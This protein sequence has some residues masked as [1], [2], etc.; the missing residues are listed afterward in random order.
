VSISVPAGR[1]PQ[2]GRSLP[3]GRGRPPD[4]SA[5]TGPAGGRGQSELVAGTSGSARS[6]CAARRVCQHQAIV[7]AMR[8]NRPP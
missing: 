5:G 8:W 2:K 6:V 4:G 3:P 1:I 7:I